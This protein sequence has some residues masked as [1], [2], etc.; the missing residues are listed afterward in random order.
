LALIAKPFTA[1]DAEHEEKTR[2][3]IVDAE[4]YLA[5]V[6]NRQLAEEATRSSIGTE[7]SRWF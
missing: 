2:V 7:I 1:E 4:R 5:I 6:A 3:K